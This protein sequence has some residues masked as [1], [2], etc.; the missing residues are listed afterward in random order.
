MRR[1]KRIYFNFWWAIGKEEDGWEFVLATPHIEIQKNCLWESDDYHMT[2]NLIFFGF[3]IGWERMKK[4][5]KRPQD[6]ALYAALR[7]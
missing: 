1:L 3:V 4:G 6:T 7:R 5:K 2:I